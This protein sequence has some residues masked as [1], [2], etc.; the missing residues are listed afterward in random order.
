MQGEE[1][2]N[3]GT[4]IIGWSVSLGLKKG[5]FFSDNKWHFC[6]SPNKEKITQTL[7]FVEGISIEFGNPNTKCMVVNNIPLT[8]HFKLL[9]I[10]RKKCK[11][12]WK[13][14]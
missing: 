8:N 1:D 10:S 5:H 12:S 6:C 11:L 2:S 7:I 3:Q 13:S 4:G 9:D 14:P